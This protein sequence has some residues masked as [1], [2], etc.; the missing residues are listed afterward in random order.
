MID[1]W[2]FYDRQFTEFRDTLKIIPKGAMILSALAE[3]PVRQ[4]PRFTGSGAYP[5]DFMIDLAVIER[6]AFTPMMFL[7]KELQPV[8]SQDAYEDL[9][10]HLVDSLPWEKLPE[11]PA[12]NAPKDH[13]ESG[14]AD[15]Y[16]YLVAIHPAG[17]DNSLQRYL[18]KIHEGSFFS[19]F[20]VK[21]PDTETTKRGR[22]NV[23]KMKGKPRRSSPCGQRGRARIAGCRGKHATPIGSAAR[24]SPRSSR[25][26]QGRGRAG[27]RSCAYH[28]PR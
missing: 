21:K 8:E 20:R 25:Y 24:R 1:H 11:M 4:P 6:D 9:N 27:A 15:H 17:Q 10:A 18:T 7:E 16:D 22:L 28:G 13:Y 3:K 5:Y 19:I 12:P 23:L 2:R 14:W 26:M